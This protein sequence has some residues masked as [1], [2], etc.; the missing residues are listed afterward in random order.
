MRLFVRRTVGMSMHPA[1]ADGQ[2]ILAYRRYADRTRCFPGDIVILS[3]A[4]RDKVKRVTGIRQGTA[5]QEIFVR[6]DNW[7]ASTDSRDFGWLPIIVIQG[8]VIWPI[9]PRYRQA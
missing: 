6:G 9:L 1:L 4:G 8:R 5:G 2:I 3:H 7:E